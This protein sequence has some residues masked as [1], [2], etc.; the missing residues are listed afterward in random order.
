MAERYYW[1][2]NESHD[3]VP[4]TAELSGDEAHHVLR[5]MRRKCGDLV[6]LFDG[7]GREYHAEITDT[8]KDRVTLRILETR[9]VDTEPQRQVTVAVSLPKGDRQKWLVEKLTEL[10]CHRLIPLQTE[11]SVA[12]C[13][14]QVLERLRRQ[15]L[16]ATKQCNRARLMQIS[17]E[18]TIAG[19][20]LQTSGFGEEEN[21]MGKVQSH[22]PSE[23]LKPEFRSRN[24]D[25][26]SE[27]KMVGW[28]AQPRSDGDFGQR[29]LSHVMQTALPKQVLVLIGPEGGFTQQEIEQ[30]VT[31]GLQPLDLGPRILRVETAAIMLTAILTWEVT[32][33]RAVTCGTPHFFAR[34]LTINL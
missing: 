3:F 11:R 17:P 22:H 6:T 24:P 10:G 1:P 29:D 25:G 7:D 8:R 18:Q 15:V 21:A 23:L 33:L 13:T 26:S 27:S 14:E 32:D 20:G 12:Q 2:C 31:F 4:Q 9:I 28:I 34:R 5:V 19:F 30:A 16:E